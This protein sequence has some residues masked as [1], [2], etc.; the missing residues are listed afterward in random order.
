M[1]TPD[2]CQLPSWLARRGRF[3]P[4]PRRVRCGTG[5]RRTGS[6]ERVAGALHGCVLLVFL[7]LTSLAPQ[8][9]EAAGGGNLLSLIGGMFPKATVIGDKEVDAPVPAWPIYQLNELI[10]YAYESRDLVDFPGFSGE[11]MNFLIGIDV[12]GGIRGVQVLY[13]HEPIFMHGLGPQPFLDFLAQYPGH[14]ITEQ[15]V[16]GK[17]RG[18]AGNDVTYFDGV[19]KATV[20]VNIANDTVL[21]SALKLARARIEAFAQGAPAEV[22]DDAFEA[23]EW[24]ELLDEGLVR[25][26]RLERATVEEGMG[27]NLE[28]FADDELFLEDG[29]EINL[30]YAYLNT[31][32]IG[33][34][35]LGEDGF[36]LLR[37]KLRPNEH[38]FAIMSEGFYGYLPTDYKPGTVPDRISIVQD[39]LPINIRDTNFV[40]ANGL[41]LMD[42][43]PRLDN[44]KIFRTRAQ[45][46]LNPSAAMQLQLMV[47][48]RKNHLVSESATFLDGDYRLPER[49]F[50]SVDNAQANEPTPMWVRMWESRTVTIGILVTALA[51][52]T[53][54]FALQRRLTA[55]AGRFRAFRMAFL[56]FTLLFIGFYAQG[57][58]SVVNIFAIQLALRDGFKLDMFLLDPVLF[59]LWIYTF[60]SLFLVGRGLFCGWL[61]PFGVM[62]SMTAWVAQKL[63][64]RQWR[65]AAR[66]HNRLIYLK[67][68][69]LAV[70]MGLALQSLQLAEQGA[71]VEPFKTAVTLGFVREWPFVLYA[72]LLLGMGLF[73]NK[74]YCRYLCPLGAGLAILGRLR[75]FSLIPRR[76]ECGSPCQLC[77]VRCE[78]AAI[79]KNG[80][81]DYNECVQCLDC[82]V[83]IQDEGQCAPAMLENKRRLRGGGA[84][85][86]E[87]LV[88][89]D[90]DDYRASA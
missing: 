53:V 51:L 69:I 34:N 24:Q 75:I 70:L 15:I 32:T 26:W 79:R 63:R 20:S 2:G 52:L 71:E 47:E 77:A 50:R 12:D 44:L 45:A 19:T 82:V 55:D 48:L 7:L 3:L 87:A 81:I 30:Y 36:E 41:E 5:I 16:V 74:F 8:A 13:H 22:R 76:A 4:A 90:P 6:G 38:A 65:I 18:G 46:G 43:A 17:A 56:A 49:F 11:Q 23:K 61:C 21:V 10:G 42:G 57:Q 29:D 80:E 54:A 64:L 73:I 62:Q 37:S 39:G 72:V 89:Q 88:L 25:R 28:V 27:W 40:D 85:G 9:Q 1:S 86:V 66:W 68:A 83:I 84:V 31:P 59:I 14:A 35:L 33:R 60:A 58:L 78:T 67:Y